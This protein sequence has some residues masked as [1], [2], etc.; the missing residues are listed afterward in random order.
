MSRASSPQIGDQNQ[1]TDETAALAAL[2][3]LGEAIAG[4]HPAA[5][6][7]ARA[8]D[9]L[10]G[11]LGCSIGAMLT[12]Q[13]SGELRAE[14][15]HGLTAAAVTYLCAAATGA[16][17]GLQMRGEPYQLVDGGDAGWTA[18]CSAAPPVSAVPLCANGQMAAVLLLVGTEARLLTP[19]QR[20][21]L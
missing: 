18:T 2:T 16:M 21:F 15:V 7:L 9:L 12:A 5:V 3:R 1:R 17:P 8:L 11:H 10:L 13:E 20:L 19:A 6:V 14:A 4:R